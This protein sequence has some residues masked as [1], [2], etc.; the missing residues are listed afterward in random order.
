MKSIALRGLAG[1]LLVLGS[2][3][4][5]LAEPASNP[6]PPQ[7]DLTGY[8]TVANA[9]TAKVVPNPG[10]V[11]QVGYLGVAVRRDG[12]GRLVVEEIQ[13]GSPADKAGVKRGDLVRRVGEQSVKTPDEFREWLQ[14]RGPG[15]TVKLG[16]KRDGKETEV[17]ATLTALSRPMSGREQ[18]VFL[19]VEL[20]DPAEGKG[21]RVESVV[22]GSGAARAGLKTGDYLAKI[23]GTELVRAARLTD[24]LTGKKPGDVLK[25]TVRREGKDLELKAT[26]SER[27]G[28]RER[29]GISLWHKES[30]KLAVVGIEFPDVKHNAKMPLKEWEEAFF[31][32]GVYAGKTNSL[33][34]MVQ[35]SLTDY[36][37]E[38]SAGKLSLS[39]KMF[40][41][42]EVGKKRAEYQQGS[43]TSNKSALPEEALSKVTA[44][45]GKEAFKDFDGFLF[46]YAGDQVR[47]NRGALYSPHAG[48]VSYQGKRRP[49]LLAPEA[50]SKMTIG[51]FVKEL[52]E[53]LGLPDLAARSENVGSEGLGVWCA[54]SN[55]LTTSRPQHFCAW[56]KEKLGWIKPT[57]IDPTL[58]QKLILAPIE[59]SPNECFKVLVRPDGSEY[60]LL[61]NRR[62]KGF[63]SDLP[64]EGLLI[65][66]VVNDRP[67]LE[68]S[69][70][71]EGPRGPLEHLAAVPY[72][73]PAN[74]AFTPETTPS[75][76]SP[77]GGGLPVRITE[78]RRLLD[79]RVAFHI[80]YQ[81]R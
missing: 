26:L 74:N 51:G 5:L 37:H 25:L 42:V 31:S 21:V 52:G 50:G 65:W 7:P 19:G 38:V 6:K 28:G 59:D 9:V 71:I 58:R 60:F 15:E 72:P 11:G 53:M 2:L 29:V 12:A 56:S 35:G 27:S 43:G 47:T 20:G 33:G 44:R 22:A 45:D 39:G 14:T 46:L 66:R 64:G 76:R 54:M 18:R 23:D 4:W 36:I 80:G 73:S 81:Y 62:K 24:M 30:L 61:E 10:R 70:G 49:Y 57:V 48:T 8:R 69:H 68:E 1:L 3:T 79:G 13:P 17:S 63:D 77:Q 32:R 55:P 41:W 75:S 78:I 40:N 16:M 34:Q 67:V